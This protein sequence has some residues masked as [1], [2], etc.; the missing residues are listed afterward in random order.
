MNIRLRKYAQAILAE[1]NIMDERRQWAEWALK[2]ADWLDPTIA[3][4][5]E[6]FRRTQT[7]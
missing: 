3:T 6:I 7:R 2:K 4:V 1:N 5:D